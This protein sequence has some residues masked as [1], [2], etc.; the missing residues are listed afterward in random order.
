MKYSD[1]IESREYPEPDLFY[2]AY[3]MLTDPKL[4]P[5]ATF[6]GKAELNNFSFEMLAYANVIPVKSKTVYGC[7]W[8]IDRKLLKELDYTEGYPF[9]YDRKTVPVFYN[10]KRYSAEIYTMTPETRKQMN[11][12]SPSSKYV[13]KIVAG[14]NN[15]KI[16]LK[17]L[18]DAINS[19]SNQ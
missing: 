3:G 11:G 2:F 10:N 8:A 5:G 15:A 4:M 9:L 14:Y 13:S 16:D 6:L 18:A 7:L 19:K 12:S 1:L 17:Q